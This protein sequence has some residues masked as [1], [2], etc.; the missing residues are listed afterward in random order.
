MLPILYEAGFV[1]IQTLWVVVVIALL[2]SSY[3]AVKRLK[4]RRVNF[5][6]FIAHSTSLL[7][8]AI[9]FSRLVYFFSNTTAYFP[10]F[11]LRTLWNF[12]AIWDQG[13]SFWGA[14][15]GFALALSYR[16]I[17]EKEPLWKW[18]DA[19]SVPVL[20]GMAIGSF[21]A[22][23]GGFSYGTPTNL[24]WGIQYEAFTVKYTVPIHPTQ[25]YAIL[26]IAAIL[27]SKKYLKEKTKFFDTDGNTTIYLTAAYSLAYFLLEFVRGDDTLM[28]LGIRIP[29]IAAMTV[30]GFSGYHLYKRY[31]HWQNVKGETPE[32]SS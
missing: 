14:L 6:L 31:K 16:I 19:L 22:F 30:L 7:I 12:V 23:L 27:W 13:F 29:Q 32:K 5:N 25:I 9:L 8:S 28:I 18:F 26:A 20:I 3:L 10:G 15:F 17:K 2:I 4:R 11:D 24:P 1:S 21:G